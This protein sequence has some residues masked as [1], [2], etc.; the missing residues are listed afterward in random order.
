MIDDSSKELLF[1]IKEVQILRSEK[2]TLME[3]LEMKTDDVKKTL[4]SEITRAE[5]ELDRH[6]K[7]QNTETNRFDYQIDELK[8]EKTALSGQLIGKLMCFLQ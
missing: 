6:L 7:H 5:E 8:Q 1:H 2:D 4:K 3:V